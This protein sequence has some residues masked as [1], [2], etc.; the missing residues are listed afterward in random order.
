MQKS[1]PLLLICLCFIFNIAAQEKAEKQFEIKGVVKDKNQAVIPGL[2]VFFKDENY[3]TFVS[4][5]LYG[6][7]FISL[8]VGNYEVTVKDN[9]SEYFKAFVNIFDNKLNPQFIE[10]IIET[11]SVCCGTSSDIPY[12]RVVK[13]DIPKYP[14]AARAVRASGSVEVKVT[15]DKSG[16]PVSAKAISGHPLLRQSAEIATINFLFEPIEFEQRELILTYVFINFLEKQKNIER[17][18]N[19]YR[20][21][22]FP[23][24]TMIDINVSKI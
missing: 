24:Q 5:D 8:P 6:N 3:E 13:S 15:I 2:P 4:A 21:L 20:I 12:P 18:S 17:Y 11:N 1:F 10:F 23:D 22:V 7:F 9:V 19:P 14:A 16:K